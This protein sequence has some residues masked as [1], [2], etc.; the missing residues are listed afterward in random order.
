M[1]NHWMMLWQPGPGFNFGQVVVLSMPLPQRSAKLPEG[2]LFFSHLVSS[3]MISLGASAW[4]ALMWPLEQYDSD[5]S[6]NLYYCLQH[7]DAQASWIFL[8][9][10]KQWR[11]VEME[12]VWHLNK[13]CLQCSEV[14]WQNLLDA[15]LKDKKCLGK[16]FIHSIICYSFDLPKRFQSTHLESLE[17][18][19][20]V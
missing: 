11:V 1:R 13:V 3:P 16:L 8:H 15:M 9:D 19:L 4:G 6:G 10:P 17:L 12:P 7:D 2:A 14:M 5:S 20:K 18:I